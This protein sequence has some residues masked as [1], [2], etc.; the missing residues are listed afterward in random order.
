MPLGVQLI[1]PAR[2]EARLL[3]AARWCEATLNVTLTPP[4]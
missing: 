1:A 3:Q 2:Q 4:V